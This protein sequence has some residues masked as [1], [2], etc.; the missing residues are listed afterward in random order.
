MTLVK[1]NQEII[2]AADSAAL[3]VEE[4]NGPEIPQ[5][6]IR[7]PRELNPRSS[8]IQPAEQDTWSQVARKIL[9]ENASLWERL[10]EL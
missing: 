3:P 1:V 9:Q 8:A 4:F 2:L 5:Q 7:Q 6:G 10:A